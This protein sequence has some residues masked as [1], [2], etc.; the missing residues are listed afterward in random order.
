VGGKARTKAI[1][2]GKVLGNT[3]RPKLSVKLDPRDLS[4]GNHKLSVVVQATK[5]PPI[6]TLKRKFKR[7]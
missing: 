3:Q 4:R 1:V 5:G 2:D 7:C 6:A